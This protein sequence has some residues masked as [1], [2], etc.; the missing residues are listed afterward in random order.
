MHSPQLTPKNDEDLVQRNVPHSHQAATP[1]VAVV[2]VVCAVRRR[3]VA[4][5]AVVA[6]VASVVSQLSKQRAIT[7][8]RYIEEDFFV[9]RRVFRFVTATFLG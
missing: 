5:A 2:V 6:V 7:I 9:V 1:F 8:V 4:V 3:I